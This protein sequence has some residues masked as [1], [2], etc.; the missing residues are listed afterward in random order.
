[1]DLRR[2]ALLAACAAMAIGAAACGGDDDGDSGGDVTTSDLTKEEWIAQA[3]QICA[4]ADAEVNQA[5]DDAGLDSDSTDDELT[6]FIAD[7]VVPSQRDQEE[8]IRELGAPEGDEEQV[9]EL[10]DS[11]DQAIS[12][13]EDDPGSVLEGGDSY[14]EVGQLAGD[15]GLETCGA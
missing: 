14:D 11:L 1:M 15:Y 3:D 10:L 2:L 5:A 8:Q 6:D 7:T 12:D 4:D 13:T 9:N